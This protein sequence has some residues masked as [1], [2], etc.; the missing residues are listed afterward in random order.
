MQRIYTYEHD[1]GFLG[2]PDKG[3]QIPGESEQASDKGQDPP[4]GTSPAKPVVGIVPVNRDQL[5]E[6]VNLQ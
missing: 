1:P 6:R 4:C 5:Y 2:A 3:G